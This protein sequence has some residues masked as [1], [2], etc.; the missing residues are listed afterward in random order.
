VTHFV[1]P[2]EAGQGQ[3]HV[4]PTLSAEGKVTGQLKGIDRV[5]DRSIHATAL[6]RYVFKAA[7]LTVPPE[8]ILEQSGSI[9]WTAQ[10]A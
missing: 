1:R 10:K 5:P 4:D 7:R 2:Y 8:L 3:E 6:T 9:L